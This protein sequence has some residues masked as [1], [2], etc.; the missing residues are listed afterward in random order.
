MMED[1]P[2]SLKTIFIIVYSKMFQAKRNSF[3]FANSV[4]EKE[5]E[6]EMISCHKVI[7]R[8]KAMN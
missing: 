2:L 3:G 7:I 8:W 5:R 6:R 4:E 1:K